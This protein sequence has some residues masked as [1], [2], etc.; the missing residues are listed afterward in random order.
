MSE[1]SRVPRQ[2]TRSDPAPGPA[3]TRGD[4]GLALR[5]L[6]LLACLVFLL[7]SLVPP[8]RAVPGDPPYPL[9][10][11]PVLLLDLAT[12]VAFGLLLPMTRRAR[13]LAGAGFF[14]FALLAR[15][16]VYQYVFWTWPGW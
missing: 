6:G 7:T 1:Q 9:F 8:R 11:A 5:W 13:V 14:A 3:R 15:V 16:V 2:T 10:S 4:L 12:A